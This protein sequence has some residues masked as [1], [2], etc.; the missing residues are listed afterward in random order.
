M[1]E[2]LRGKLTAAEL[3][4]LYD[5]TPVAARI[6]AAESLD[7]AAALVAEGFTTSNPQFIK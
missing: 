6:S 1:M 7:L 5:A 2:L 4:A 3:I